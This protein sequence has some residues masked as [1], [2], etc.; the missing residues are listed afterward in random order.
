MVIVHRLRA[1][2]YWVIKL[3]WQGIGTVV[4]L[5]VLFL[6]MGGIFAGAPLWEVFR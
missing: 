6:I 3:D 2:A 1:A 5:V 4:L